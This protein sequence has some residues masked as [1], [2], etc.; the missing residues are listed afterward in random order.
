[1]RFEGQGVAPQWAP[2]IRRLFKPEGLEEARYVR[3]PD[4]TNGSVRLDANNFV[5][6]NDDTR[7]N[8]AGALIDNV[9]YVVSGVVANS[10]G[11]VG[12]DITAEAF[13]ALLASNVKHLRLDRL[14]DVAGKRFTT[15][16]GGS[17]RDEG[18][19]LAAPRLA[20]FP[21]AHT[22]GS[23]S[24]FVCGSVGTE[25]RGEVGA[26]HH[27][28]CREAVLSVRRTHSQRGRKSQRSN[29]ENSSESGQPVPV[30]M[31]TKPL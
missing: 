15:K 31:A 9:R 27:T 4:A 11:T 21:L 17:S 24:V 12:G 18:Q 2:S 30:E 7:P 13:K 3:V 10:N 5:G 14:G 23:K 28:I 8:R 22:S 25:G 6:E 29:N 20:P 19:D 1:M 16:N 26:K